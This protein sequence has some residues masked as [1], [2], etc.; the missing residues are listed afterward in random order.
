MAIEH[1]DLGVGN[2]AANGDLSHAVRSC[3]A[4]D[5]FIDRCRH[6]GFRG[7]IAIN[8][9]QVVT[10]QHLPAC[11]RRGFRFLAA[12]HQQSQPAWQRGP[13]QC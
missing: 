7:A 3:L 2:R 12:D 1:I 5:R 4:N 13:Q 9:L 8:P 11:E 6:R 10:R